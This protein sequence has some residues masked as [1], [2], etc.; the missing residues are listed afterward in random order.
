MEM[1]IGFDEGRRRSRK[2]ILAGVAMA[3]AAGAG[4]FWFLSRV[5][6]QASTQV[7]AAKVS[8]VVAARTIAARKP[9]EAGD[10]VVREVTA[11]PTTQQG[12][13]N[14]PT[15]L[16]NR[17]P[18]VTILAGQLVTSNLFTFGSEVSG[19]L[20]ILGPEE[21]VTPESPNWRA[22]SLTVPDERAV[23]GMVVAGSTVDV[24]MTASVILP[25]ALLTGGQYYADKSTKITYQDVPILARNGNMYV[26]KVT[27]GVAEEITHLAAAGNVQFSF[28]L[29]PG[30]DTRIVD[31]TTLGETTNI[32]IE[33][34]GLPIPQVYPRADS[35]IPVGAPPTI[36][37]PAPSAATAIVAS[38][39]PSASATP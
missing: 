19:G 18:G 29:R 6:D 28:A 20:A 8:V 11:D 35:T 9:I 22:V 31:A 27:D 3:I 39:A 33:R 15:S 30:E 2:I 10:L 23:A 24:F 37:S 13:Y 34:Y 14:D 38:P 16:V 26:I 4:S 36:P 17:V 21:K 12:I 7:E 25:Q 1:G 32:I 5:Q